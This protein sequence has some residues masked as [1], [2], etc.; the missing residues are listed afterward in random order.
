MNR[1]NTLT[2]DVCRRNH[3]GVVVNDYHN[4]GSGGSVA[5]SRHCDTPGSFTC[6]NVVTT[7]MVVVAV[8]TMMMTMTMMK[9]M[10][11]ASSSSLFRPRDTSREERGGENEQGSYMSRVPSRAG[12]CTCMHDTCVYVFVRVCYYKIDCTS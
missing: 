10:M 11:M 3:L 2:I 4:R 1:L 6:P 9:M 12:V 8:M 5:R 7:V